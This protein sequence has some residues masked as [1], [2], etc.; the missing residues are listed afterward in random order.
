MADLYLDRYLLAIRYALN[1]IT[2]Q[3]SSRFTEDL[4][5][6][7]RIFV[8]GKGRS[9]LVA[10]MFAMRLVHLGLIAYSIGK[11]ATPKVLI[12]DMVVFA[13]GSG[14]TGSMLL[15]LV[16]AK[17]AGAYS[18]VISMEPESSLCRIADLP[19]IIQQDKSLYEK[20]PPSKVLCGTMF[21][22]ALLIFLD[23]I[24]GRLMDKTGQTFKDL[25]DRHV[26]IE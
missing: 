1:H 11:P 3:D 22:Q 13:S 8:M 19:L 24:I 26:N 12:G 17:R 7:E 21:E 20:N 10:D 14:E 25:S 4:L 2:E 23:G 18:A 9:G 15:A 6:H 5:G 16:E